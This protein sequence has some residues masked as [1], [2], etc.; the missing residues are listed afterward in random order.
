MDAKGGQLKFLPRGQPF[1]DVKELITIHISMLPRPPVTE[2]QAQAKTPSFS[3][4]WGRPRRF[5]GSLH[6]IVLF[7]R[8]LAAH[9]REKLA[10][11]AVFDMTSYA[12][13]T[14]GEHALIEFLLPGF[15]TA[16]LECVKFSKLRQAYPRLMGLDL[17]DVQSSLY[18]E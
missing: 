17:D 1:C 11:L 3:H 10:K 18:W 15:L 16:L 13:S 2:G 12:D 8:D 9:F 5:D 7:M 6:H 4:L 14:A